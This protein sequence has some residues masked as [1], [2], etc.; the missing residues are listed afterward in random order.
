[1]FDDYDGSGAYDFND[2]INTFFPNHGVPDTWRN[3]QLDKAGLLQFPID[4]DCP[5]SNTE[6]SLF[7][8][9][10]LDSNIFQNCIQKS[11]EEGA[12]GIPGDWWQVAQT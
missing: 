4:S 9:A 7:L 8:A 6:I 1:M 11:S 3:Q 5:F 10:H 2:L 12:D